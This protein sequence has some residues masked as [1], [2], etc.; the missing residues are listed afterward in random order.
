MALLRTAKSVTKRVQRYVSQPTVW[1]DSQLLSCV[2]SRANV[3]EE[4]YERNSIECRLKGCTPR[5]THRY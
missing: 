3:L 5:P 4:S 2:S 1:C